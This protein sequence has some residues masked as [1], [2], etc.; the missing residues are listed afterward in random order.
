MRLHPERKLS[1]FGGYGV[2]IK[3][4]SMHNTPAVFWSKNSN[5]FVAVQTDNDIH[6]YSINGIGEIRWR[7]EEWN[8]DEESQDA[9]A[10][11]L[12]A[13]MPETAKTAPAP[14]NLES[15]IAAIGILKKARWEM[16]VSPYSAFTFLSRAESRLENELNAYFRGQK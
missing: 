13:A 2:D 9:R 10:Y 5:S 7:L 11:F 12:C 4:T 3:L 6:I 15:T 16:G 14:F 1:T 8:R